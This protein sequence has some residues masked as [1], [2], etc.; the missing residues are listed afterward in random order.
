MGW[1]ILLGES[2][3]SSFGFNIFRYISCSVE[4][5]C[6]LDR[7]A[8]ALAEKFGYGSV[9]EMKKDAQKRFSLLDNGILDKPSARLFLINVREPKFHLIH[10]V[11]KIT[12]VI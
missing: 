3:S 5:M 6:V 1:S 11:S 8:G 12:N 2:S 9:E 7:L 10:L 4:L